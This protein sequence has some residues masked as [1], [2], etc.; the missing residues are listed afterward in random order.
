MVLLKFQ[1]FLIGN[2]GSFSLT[3]LRYTEADIIPCSVEDPDED[4]ESRALRRAYLRYRT[5]KLKLVRDEGLKIII[6]SVILLRSIGARNVL[7]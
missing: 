5:L 2:R 7:T 4:K 1:H 6:V 3:I